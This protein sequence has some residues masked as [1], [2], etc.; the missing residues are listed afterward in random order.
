M[1]YFGTDGIRGKAYDFITEELSFSLGKSMFHFHDKAKRII[2]ARDTRESGLMVVDNIKKGVLMAGLDICDLGVYAT[3][4][5]AFIANITDSIG[6]MVTASHNPYYDNGIKL[7]ISGSKSLPE[8]EAII[9]D[10]IDKGINLEGV[11]LGKE[12]AL[13]G[14]VKEY[15]R[16]YDSFRQKMNL[17]IG[18]DLANGATISSALKVLPPLVK[19][20]LVIGNSPDGFNIN[21]DCGSTHLAQIKALVLNER[22]DLGFAFD[23]DG[24]RLLVIDDEGDVLDGDLLIYLTAKYLKATNQLTNNLVVLSKMSNLGIIKAL[25]DLNIEVIQTEV[26]DKYI[27]EALNEKNAVLGG[28]NSGH[29]I[30]RTILETGDGVLN[31]WFL[32][33]ILDYYQTK[34]SEIKK[35]VKYYPDK[36]VNIKDIDKEIINDREIVALVEK[37][38]TLLGK[39][40]KVLVRPSGTEPLI[41]V[42]V[43]AKTNELVDEIIDEIVDK[44]KSK[45]KGE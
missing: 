15:F 2:I 35:E 39:D 6:I 17:R 9:E 28:E 24:D 33:K 21:K 13:P 43:S 25:N 31:A 38:R 34:F 40:G 44:I 16:L 18:L 37:Y 7:F 41:R 5:L 4:V 30:N 22:L 12:V 27:F 45:Q 32:L 8:D 10:V 36:L 3:P 20:C 42:S 26:G 29:V 23:G 19:E 14:I 1:K 11:K